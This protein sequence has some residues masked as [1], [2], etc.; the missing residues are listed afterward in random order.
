MKPVNQGNKPPTIAA[1]GK[2]EAEQST[3][4][5]CSESITKGIQQNV[6]EHLEQVF[7]NQS[8]ED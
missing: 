2:E 1:P 7:S 4:E 8:N 5:D 6:W 3:K